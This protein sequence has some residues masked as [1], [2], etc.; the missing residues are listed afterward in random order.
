MPTNESSP[1]AHVVPDGVC[2]RVWVPESHRVE[3]VLFDA[4]GEILRAVPLAATG[5]GYF[6]AT[7]PAG[8]AGDRYKFRLNGDEGKTFPDP[9]SRYQP[10]G[11]HGPSQ[12][13]DGRSFKWTHGG[14]R[15]G[16]PHIEADDR[17]PWPSLDEL[18]IYELHIG[19]FTPEGT[20]LAAI[21]K[22]DNLKELGVTALE[23][24][25]LADFPGRWNWGYDGVFLYAP[26]RA[27]GKPDDLRSLVQAAHSIGLFVILDAVYNHLGP[28]GNYLGAYTKDYFNPAHHTPWGDALN[29][30]GHHHGPVREFFLGNPIYW[31]E[32]FHFDGFRLDAIHAIIDDSPRH[33][34]ADI[35]AA[36]HER[37]G[38]VFAEDERNAAFLATPEVD[39]G[40]GLDG[41]WADDFHHTV[42]VA[43]TGEQESY[44]KNFD[45]T[46]E[47]LY[48]TLANGWHYRGQATPTEGKPRG[49]ECAQLPTH[50]FCYCISNH[51]QVGN[52]AFG[53]RL[54]ASCSPEAYRAASALLCLA[55]YTPLI[56]QG[57]EWAASTPFLY[58]TDHNAELGRLVTEGRRKEFKGF[59]AF[60][61]EA[62]I[63]RIPDPQAE[64][65]FN[66]SKLNWQEVNEGMHAQTRALYREALRLRREDPALRCRARGGKWEYT[67][68]TPADVAGRSSVSATCTPNWS[69]SGS[70]DT[71]WLDYT[72]PEG[73]R[74]TVIFN[75]RGK[76]KGG[77]LDFVKP[78]YRLIFSSNDPRF[79]GTGTGFD[80]DRQRIAFDLPELVVLRANA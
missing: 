71:V 42:R 63:K 5:D 64:S 44:L 75:L 11:V 45:G 77:P 23:I 4:G 53:E 67:D 21:D 48:D 12:V 10:E 25:P 69:V 47:E 33:I 31:M 74:T 62:S 52:R 66:A 19:T 43:L 73:E 68:P 61:D 51:D 1:G 17:R 28:D 30:D 70:G 46:G 39:G 56:F 2:Y 22:L 9:L 58:F 54:T 29:F 24:M 59:A 3:A 27:Y 14:M 16:N 79:G 49:S 80:A 20:F 6:Q 55:P 72:S 37:G 78:T 76:W 35:A 38:F 34:L 57:Q 15:M 26:S 7:D 65:T 18:V 13:I 8:G 50:A 32:E 60:A 41:L 36:I 40:T